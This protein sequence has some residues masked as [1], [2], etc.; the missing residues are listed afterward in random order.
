MSS[1]GEMRGKRKEAVKMRSHGRAIG[2]KDS[3][4]IRNRSGV[5]EKCRIRRSDESASGTRVK[6]SR[7]L[8]GG[9]YGNSIAG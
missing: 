9:D 2:C 5:T 7:G 3:G 8:M 6:N 4:T 1:V